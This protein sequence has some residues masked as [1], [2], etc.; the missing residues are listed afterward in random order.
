M[1]RVSQLEPLTTEHTEDHGGKAE[2]PG[3]V[4]AARTAGRS[5]ALQESRLF[6]LAH[7]LG[8]IIRD[9]HFFDGVKLGLEE[10][11]VALFVNEHALE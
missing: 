10:I 11:G 7:L 6:S 4:G 8:E 9:A 2:T 3:G 1:H 5:P